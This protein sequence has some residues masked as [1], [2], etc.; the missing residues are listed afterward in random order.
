MSDQGT[1]RLL[2]CDFVVPGVPA[3]VGSSPRRRD[4]WKQRVNSAAAAA[5]PPSVGPLTQPVAVVLVLF[6]VGQVGDVDNKIKYTLDGMVGVILSDDVLVQQVTISRQDLRDPLDLL[7]PSATL[8]GAL[9]SLGA[10]GSP[11]VYV[12][13]AQPRPFQELLV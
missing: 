13:V 10:A 6:D 12:Q 11:F 3:G 2:P 7:A 4:D 9:G 8:A 5:W 1:G